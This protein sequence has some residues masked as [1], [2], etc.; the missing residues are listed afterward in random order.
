MI[1]SVRAAHMK[2]NDRRLAI[3]GLEHNPP[4]AVAHDAEQARMLMSD[5]D[6]DFDEIAGYANHVSERIVE[7]AIEHPE[8]LV[9]DVVKG[10]FI[11]GVLTGIL[12]ERLPEVEPGSV[13]EQ[14]GHIVLMGAGKCI[15]CE[16]EVPTPNF[17]EGNDESA[18][19]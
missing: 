11:D 15:N 6:I 8:M 3:A 18:S 19:D 13:C 1:A 16:Y 4:A 17:E 9:V 7:L 5:L 14:H 12:K 10:V 2:L